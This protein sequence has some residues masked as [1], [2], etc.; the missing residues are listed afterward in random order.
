M[1]AFPLSSEHVAL[2]NQF[3]SKTVQNI[4]ANPYAQLTLLRPTN[5]V[6]VRLDLR[7]ARSETSGELFEQMSAEID[8]IASIF[9]MQGV[10]RLIPRSSC[11]PCGTTWTRA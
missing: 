9:G 10:F 11:R 2:S 5:G 4:R 1:T 3:F 8:A 6:Q 7:Y